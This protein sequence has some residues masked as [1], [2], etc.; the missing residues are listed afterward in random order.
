MGKTVSKQGWENLER[1]QEAAAAGS[2]EEQVVKEIWET[3]ARG[4]LCIFM[5]MPDSF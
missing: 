5:A 3:E 2:R 1:Q 4:D